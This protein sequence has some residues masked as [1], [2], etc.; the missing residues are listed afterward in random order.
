MDID[1]KWP[2]WVLRQNF[3][4]VW[5]RAPSARSAIEIAANRLGPMGGWKVGPSV[6]QEVFR[7]DEYREH[8]RPGDYTQ[9]GSSKPKGD[10]KP[11][12]VTA[13]GCDMRGA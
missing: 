8:A 2:E 4:C 3:A 5:V 6:D 1:P 7:A 10:S 9:T 13:S 11:R 12:S